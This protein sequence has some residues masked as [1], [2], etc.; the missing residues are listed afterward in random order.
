VID[1]PGV[2]ALGLAADGEGVEAAFSDVEEL[3]RECRFRDCAHRA[4]PGCAVRAAMDAGDLTEE[5]WAAYLQFVDEQERASSRALDRE[6]QAAMRR[7]AAS[8]QQARDAAE[9]TDR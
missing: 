2:R 1:N 7:E 9:S 4:E 8:L 5:R 3:G 6:R